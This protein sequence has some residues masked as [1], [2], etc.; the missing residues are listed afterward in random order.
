M[1][2]TDF[3]SLGGSKL[4]YREYWVLTL[5]SYA[6]AVILSGA[7]VTAL[8]AKY[9]FDEHSNKSESAFSR[10]KLIALCVALVYVVSMFILAMV[11]G[12]YVFGGESG[13]LFLGIL[14]AV[15]ALMCLIGVFVKVPY[16]PSYLVSA[17]NWCIAGSAFFL[18]Q[19]PT[20]FDYVSRFVLF[21]AFFSGVPLALKAGISYVKLTESDASLPWME[22]LDRAVRRVSFF[23]VMFGAFA[24]GMLV[25]YLFAGTCITIYGPNVDSS[26]VAFA[27]TLRWNSRMM[28]S[29]SPSPCSGSD[30]CHVYLTAG[31]D[32]TS[33]VFVN[34]HLPI[35]IK[36]KF[37][38]VDVN[39]GQAIVKA[40]EFPT[41][42]LDEHDDR[43]VF[44]AYISGLAP[45]GNHSFTLKTDEGPIGEALY[46][47][48]TAP[49]NEARFVVAGDAGI[50]D[51]TDEIMSQ[52]IATRP[53][54]AIIGGDVAYDNG[55]LS[56]ACTWDSFL[57]MWETKRVDGRFLVPLSFAAGNHDL[58]VNDNSDGAFDRQQ[59]QCDLDKLWRAKPLIFGWFPHE[60]IESDASPRLQ[61]RPVC[62]RTT[63]RKHMIGGL[64]NLW[65]LDSAYAV[66][67]ATNVE[68]VDREMTAV[69]HNVA[70]Y[71]VPLYSSNPQ[72]FP[73]GAYLRDAWL[74]PMID[75]YGFA[76]CFENH[77]HTYKRTKPMYGDR[78]VD[79]TVSGSPRGTVFLGDGKMGIH[80]R[81]VP[82]ENSIIKPRDNAI[83]AKTGVQHHFFLVETSVADPRLQIK[84]INNLGNI[85]DRLRTLP[86]STIPKAVA[87]KDYQSESSLDHE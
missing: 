32:L 5:G 78:P 44:S 58:G 9:G 72:D 70:V 36:P 54:I 13:W 63:L 55:L 61:P 68:Y 38:A 48:R 76:A 41:Y 39:N 7:M 3:Y 71:H 66:S 22:K 51:F 12:L 52:M 77:A 19:L 35:A 33:E 83:F 85:F 45:G 6:V 34:V 47:F 16:L 50:T 43:L 20:M 56:C 80:G 24:C 29:F 79:S 42:L 64:M 86:E 2:F 57:R 53:Y 26:W 25:A 67:A 17:S 18:I 74:G 21:V 8:C 15:Q 1:P 73:K 65:V 10:P 31:S 4:T 62:S 11:N 75:K 87:G 82:D 30:P 49:F 37:L 14:M 59:E 46:E 40:S 60:T 23:A 28:R 81:E 84:V 69:M 27:G